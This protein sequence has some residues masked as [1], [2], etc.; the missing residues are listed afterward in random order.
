MLI[1]YYDMIAEM[2]TNKELSPV[3]TDLFFR[4]RKLNISIAFL[5]QSYFKVTKT[6]KLNATNHFAMKIPSKREL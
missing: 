6:I 1:V 2:K 4:G 5:S 3:T